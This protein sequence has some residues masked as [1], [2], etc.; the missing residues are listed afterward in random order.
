MDPNFWWVLML[1]RLKPG[2]HVAEA[3]DALDVL[4]KR[5]VA[6]AKPELTAR[7]CRAST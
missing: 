1:G 4:L 2:V 5:T 7:I 3:R 6:S